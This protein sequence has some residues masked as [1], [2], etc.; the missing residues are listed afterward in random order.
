M[1][2]VCFL[3]EEKAGAI[4]TGWCHR[5]YSRRYS[6]DSPRR[7]ATS[8]GET[9]RGR[10]PRDDATRGAARRRKRNRASKRHGGDGGRHPRTD[11]AHNRTADTRRHRARPMA[12]I[13]VRSVARSMDAA[14]GCEEP[15]KCQTASRMHIR[16]ASARRGQPIARRQPS[17]VWRLWQRI[18][19]QQRQK[20]IAAF[21]VPL[22]LGG[23]AVREAVVSRHDAHGRSRAV[24]VW[25]AKC[26]A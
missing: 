7:D 12:F 11:T 19:G 26:A 9:R 16:R 2:G 8:S 6:N 21:T 1:P 14:C 10:A 15:R 3:V 23:F 20:V 17:S 22:N 18:G 5:R 25:R 4:K 13:T 24:E